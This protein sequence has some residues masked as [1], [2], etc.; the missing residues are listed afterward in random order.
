M[1]TQANCDPTLPTAFSSSGILVAMGDGSVHSVS[2]SCSAASWGAAVFP[3]D[4][5]IPGNDFGS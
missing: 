5:N 2:S 3:A 1:P 4:G